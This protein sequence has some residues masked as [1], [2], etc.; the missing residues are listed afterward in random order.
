MLTL[1][2]EPSDLAG[3]SSA[4]PRGKDSL[5][6]AI[7]RLKICRKPRNFLMPL[8]LCQGVEKFLDAPV[9]GLR[10]GD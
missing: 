4:R 8:E 3:K 9:A 2:Q 6:L 10:A 7:K 1:C 5:S